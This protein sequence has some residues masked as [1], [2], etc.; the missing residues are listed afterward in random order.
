M[1]KEWGID[2]TGRRMVFA[3][4]TTDEYGRYINPKDTDIIETYGISGEAFSE[5]LLFF[6]QCS[7][8]SKE[9]IEL[10][11]E[12]SKSKTYHITRQELLDSRRW[13]N[14]EYYFYFIMFTKK[15]I[16][17]YSW[18][19]SK[20]DDVQL[21]KYHRIY[22]KGFI[23]FDPF[24]KEDKDVQNN[25]YFATLTYFRKKGVDLTEW[26]EWCDILAG[27]KTNI[28]FKNDFS[29]IEHGW[30]SSEFFHFSIELL[31]VVMNKSSLVSIFREAFEVWTLAGFSYVPESMLIKT[32]EYIA[33]KGTRA[34]VYY[35]TLSKSK[36]SVEIILKQKQPYN[37]K[38]DDIY[39]NSTFTTGLDCV[40]AIFQ[41]TIKKL[42]R[43]DKLPNLTKFDRFDYD[44]AVF[45]FNW[46]KRILT[47]P[48]LNL[49]L[50]NLLSAIVFLS[51]NVFHITYDIP[52]ITIYVFINT[53]LI[54]LR[55]FSIERHKRK[56][57]EKNIE[58]LIDDSDIRLGK[59]EKI[60]D[61]LLR[62]K[63]L[64]EIKVKKRTNELMYKNE[65]LAEE[66]EKSEKL[67]LNI[68]P[69]MIAERLK[70]GEQFI[71]DKFEEA[72]IVF[73]DIVGFT[74]I[75]SQEPPERVVTM[76]D[77]I[78]TI[79]DKVCEK[80][81]MEK[82]KTI[83]DCYMAVAGIPLPQKD[84]TV[85]AA[86]FAIE[87]MENVSIQ[88]QPTY[89]DLIHFRCGIDCG[90]VVAG[91]IGKKKFIYDLW[92]DVVNIASRLEEYG[93]MDK[94]HVSEKFYNKFTSGN[95]NLN[96]KFIERG[97]IEIKGK[98]VMKTYF[99]ESNEK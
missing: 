52:V 90:P 60:S 17:N 87:A 30:M 16:G 63:Q 34:Y 27:P 50:F 91:I 23:D 80:Y 5:T 49:S 61:E 32:L 36:N 53:Y 28:S 45:A 39:Y 14:C 65:R 44:K 25:A 77:E 72:S 6:E 85:S 43:L 62:E 86:K 70:S 20:G 78:F 76:L 33:N 22:E 81:G 71:A 98:G 51:P 13:Y 67:L 92:A 29:K 89:G 64:L 11:N 82:I 8:N 74:T 84:H 88:L 69:K 95:G 37:A 58:I 4:W 55:Y 10:L 18:R 40:I 26:L 19:Y 93:L 12:H 7:G 94:I 75:A 79:F 31:K 57:A 24:G 73:I 38:K 2:I 15:L 68:L 42:L 35:I 48:W 3:P 46:D 1:K 97:D 9:L 99:L 54:F 66:R 96:I 59:L 21:S 47:I 56:Q 41:P 83:G